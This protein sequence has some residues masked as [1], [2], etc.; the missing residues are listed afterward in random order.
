M[1]VQSQVVTANNIVKEYND[2][3]QQAQDMVSEHNKAMVKDLMAVGAPLATVRRSLLPEPQPC[4]NF[5]LRSIKRFLQLFSWTKRSLNAQGNY[6]EYTDPRLVASR[7]QLNQRIQEGN[8][9]KHLVLN[10]DQVWRQSMRFGRY[11]Y[12]QR[13]GRPLAAGCHKSFW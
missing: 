10:L 13:T 11:V 1:C 6:L 9:H 3:L 8:A 5:T 7:K 2:G 12:T 4:P